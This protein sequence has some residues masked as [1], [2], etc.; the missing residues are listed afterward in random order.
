MWTD[1]DIQELDIYKGSEKTPKIFN[2]IFAH[3]GFS[4][5][6]KYFFE[7]LLERTRGFRIIG[8]FNA[9]K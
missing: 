1:Y 9:T 4:F 8:D 6:Y 3:N 5:D 2:Y 7:S